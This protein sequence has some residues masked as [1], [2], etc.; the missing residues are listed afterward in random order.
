[1]ARH[2]GDDDRCSGSQEHYR[3]LNPSAPTNEELVQKYSLIC[4]WTTVRPETERRTA[5]QAIQ[6]RQ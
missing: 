1:M 2:G 5:D 3:H 6:L 4:C